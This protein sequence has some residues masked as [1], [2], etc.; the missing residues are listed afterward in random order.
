MV[1]IELSVLARQ[2]LAR[3]IQTKEELEREMAAWEE[4]RNELGVE[5]PW[6]FTTADAPIDLRRLYSS[7]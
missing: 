7:L 5:I 2:C 4:K 6:H 3:Q 1:E